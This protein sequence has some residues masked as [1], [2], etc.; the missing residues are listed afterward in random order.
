MT[1]QFNLATSGNLADRLGAI[2]AIKADIEKLEK[3]VKSQ[4]LAGDTRIID[5]EL[6][7]VVVTTADRETIDSK[8]V[9]AVLTPEELSVVLKTTAVT[10]VRCNAR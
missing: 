8:A 6:F 5:G 7:H 3:E 9:R 10:T 1:I 4:I 2:L